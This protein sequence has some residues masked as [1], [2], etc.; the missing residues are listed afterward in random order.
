MTT[1]IA[2]LRGINVGGHHKVPMAELRGS[3]EKLKFEKVI[4]IL[5]SGNVI[6]DSSITT[7]ETIEKLIHTH[8]EKVFDFPIPV[9]VRTAKMIATLLE[10]DPFKNITLTKDIRCYVSFLQ[11]DVQIDFSLPWISDDHAYQVLAKN[12]K[13]IISVLDLSINKTPKA[14]KA[15]EKYFG[16]NITTRNWK[17]IKRIEQ[18]LLKNG[19]GKD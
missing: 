4:T 6:F 7:P 9:M 13:T 15:L 3:L 18:K 17:T 12:D 8:L 10:S 11:E 14:M 2:F 19:K 1:Y 16:K 5:N